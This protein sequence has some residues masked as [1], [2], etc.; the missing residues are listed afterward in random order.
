LGVPNTDLDQQQFDQ[1]IT[2]TKGVQPLDF[3]L[4]IPV[5]P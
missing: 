2:D 1:A 5:S 3:Q 4:A